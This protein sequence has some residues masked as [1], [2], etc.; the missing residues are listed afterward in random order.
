VDVSG[1]TPLSERLSRHGRAGA[2][3]VAAIIN[4]LFFELVTILFDHG[5]TLLKFGGDAML[6]LVALGVAE[7]KNVEEVQQI[8]LNHYRVLAAQGDETAVEYL[9]H[10]CTA[11]MQQAELIDDPAVRQ[12]FLDKVNVNREIRKEAGNWS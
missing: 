12:T 5:G 3:Q 10:A 6:G 2:E 8:Y 11:M 7:Q 9:Q 4:D 1:F